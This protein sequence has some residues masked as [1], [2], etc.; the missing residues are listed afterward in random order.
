MA[1]SATS[2]KPGQSGNPGGRPKAMSP[3]LREA[4]KGASVRAFA[5][6]RRALRN[7]DPMVQL[8]AANA[9]LDRAYGRPEQAI[10]GA[11]GED[12]PPIHVT[13]GRPR[14]G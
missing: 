8:R 14:G 13:F 11:D 1:A 12:L 9:I 5:V 2:F 10:T 4:F 3:E 7:K 6:L